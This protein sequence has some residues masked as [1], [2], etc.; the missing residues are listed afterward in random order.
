[1]WGS[2]SL[3]KPTDPRL[4]SID[5]SLE[6]GGL[7]PRELFDFS[8]VP[9]AH[10]RVTLTFSQKPA[11]KENR[12]K[13]GTLFV[14][15]LRGFDVVR[16]ECTVFV[17]RSPKPGWKPQYQAQIEDEWRDEQEERSMTAYYASRR[18]YY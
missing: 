17:S 12:R 9:Q 15:S 5:I 13:L 10:V 4:E 3:I 6:I 16:N 18:K 2:I 1:M 7:Y 14:E 8:S 11:W